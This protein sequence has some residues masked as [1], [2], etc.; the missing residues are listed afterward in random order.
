VSTATGRVT[1]VGLSREVFRE[2]VS[3]RLANIEA[4]A[5]RAPEVGGELVIE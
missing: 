2:Q 4:A 1:V 3:L 5:R